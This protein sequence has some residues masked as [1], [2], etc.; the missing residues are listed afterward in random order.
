MTQMSKNVVYVK[1][2]SQKHVAV[3]LLPSV[4]DVTERFH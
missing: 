3:S 1:R 4:P 2:S